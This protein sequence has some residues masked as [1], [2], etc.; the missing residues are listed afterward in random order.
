MTKVK[1]HDYQY[2]KKK[3]VFM[4]QHFNYTELLTTNF[5]K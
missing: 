3:C 1:T 4:W 2:I 5:T